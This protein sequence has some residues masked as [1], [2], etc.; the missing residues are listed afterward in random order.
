MGAGKTVLAQGVAEGL[1]LDPRQIQSPTFTLVHE[2]HSETASMIHVDLYR[3][4][5]EEVAGVGLEE[6]L[7]RPGVKV[8]EWA[9]R[10]PF[11]VPGAR[12]VLLRRRAAGGR[13]AEESPGKT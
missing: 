7:A 2:H 10:L 11:E 13:E 6:T 8:I 9:E 1:G 5:P 12:R 4:G 3:L